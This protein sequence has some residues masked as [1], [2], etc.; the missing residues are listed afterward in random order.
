[1][2]LEVLKE[3]SEAFGVSGCEEEVRKLIIEAIQG[4]VDDYSVDTIG[5]LIALK[6]GLAPRLR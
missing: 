4:Y 3:L 1:M 5:N 2:G 6:K